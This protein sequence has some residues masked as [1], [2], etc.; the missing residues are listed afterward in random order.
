MN[1]IPSWKEL[2][3]P[4]RPYQSN[5]WLFRNHVRHSLC[6]RCPDHWR[7]SLSLRALS[8]FS[9]VRLSSLYARFYHSHQW[10]EL[11]VGFQRKLVLYW[12]RG[13]RV[14][15]ANHHLPASQFFPSYCRVYAR[16]HCHIWKCMVWC[17]LFWLNIT[18]PCY[19]EYFLDASIEDL[20]VLISS[21]AICVTILLLSVAWRA[22]N[23]EKLLR[24]LDLPEDLHLL[25]PRQSYL[26]RMFFE[27]GT[28]RITHL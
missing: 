25:N 2:L 8:S 13:L 6:Q 19:K 15:F 7:D 9:L 11:L 26:Y 20:T 4:L 18:S 14:L 27:A 17:V 22:L 24:F 28:M 5:V 16:I 12:C 3:T 23:V 10:H 1:Q 21:F